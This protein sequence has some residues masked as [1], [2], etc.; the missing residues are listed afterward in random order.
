M[1]TAEIQSGNSMCLSTSVARSSCRPGPERAD[2]HLGPAEEAHERAH[3]HHR[4]APPERPLVHDLAREIATSARWA[5]ARRDVA[6]WIMIGART[7]KLMNAPMQHARR[8]RDSHEAADAPHREVERE[9]Q[10]QLLHVGAEDA[11]HV[12]VAS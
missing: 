11:Q 1:P 6:A 2:D 9:A 4:D 7:T 3:H 12:A 5:D 10:A 8:H